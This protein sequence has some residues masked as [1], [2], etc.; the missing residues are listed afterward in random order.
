MTIDNVLGDAMRT[1]ASDSPAE[2]AVAATVRGRINR[3]HRIRRT[4]LA[5]AAAVAAVAAIATTASVLR[6]PAPSD[7]IRV[8]S[9]PQIQ[10]STALVSESSSPVPATNGQTTRPATS[11]ANPAVT[12]FSA[13]CYTTADTGRTDNHLAIS[14][15]IPIGPHAVELCQQIEAESTLVQSN[16]TNLRGWEATLHRIGNKQNPYRSALV[17]ARR[18]NGISAWRGPAGPRGCACRAP[19]PIWS[20]MG[21]TATLPGYACSGRWTRSMSAW[22]GRGATRSH[23]WNRWRKPSATL[24]IGSRLMMK[25]PSPQTLRCAPRCGRL[26]LRSRKR[27]RRRGGPAR[28]T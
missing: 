17:G 22:R 15:D 3:R 12:G 9:P 5:T 7:E 26:Q 2:V 13:R 14:L 16:Q 19:R 27:Q 11:T 23:S 25:M 6:Q 4:A 18:K 24:C 20:L 1:L 10:T 8:V 21:S 28:L